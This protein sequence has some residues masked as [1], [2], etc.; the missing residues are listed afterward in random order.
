MGSWRVGVTWRFDQRD[1]A[2]GIAPW[3]RDADGM[4]H[5]LRA[6][7]LESRMPIPSETSTDL[8]EPNRRQGLRRRGRFSRPLAAPP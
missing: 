4:L 1:A 5:Q 2:E 6:V 7:H 3:T 8:R